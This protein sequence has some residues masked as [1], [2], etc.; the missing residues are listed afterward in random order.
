ME[1]SDIIKQKIKNQGPITF[2][3]FMEMALY[4]PGLGYYTSAKEKIGEKGDF[5]TSSSLSPAFGAMIAKQLE[6]MFALLGE[7][8]FTVVEYGAGTGRL[9][10]DI[11]D[12]LKQNKELYPKLNYC[13]VEKS[14]AMRAKEKNILNEKVTWCN[15]ISELPPLKGCVL[16]NELVDNFAV[17][18]VVMQDELMEVFVDFQNGFTEVLKPASKELVNY[19]NELKVELPKGFRTEINLDATLWMKDVSKVLKRGY[20]LT[21]DYG[22]PSAELYC[23]QRKNGTIACYNKH[24]VNYEPFADIGR[25]DITSHVNFSALCL[26]GHK[27]GLELCGYRDQGSFLI[28]LGFKDHIKTKVER[29]SDLAKL[30]QEVHL[31]NLL[32]EDMGRK[33]K[34]LI[35]QKETPRH[36][37]SGLRPLHV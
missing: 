1:L 3:D 29:K 10:K 23:E 13:I 15:S 17:H 19:L 6:E 24:K 9:C 25:Q 12:H 26:W 11:L 14:P 32:L 37:L 34:V 30:K 31:S 2:R 27:H 4:Y 35:Q 18:Q 33:F 8:K 28:A 7:E 36:P 22:Y 20:V 21:I 5:Y 16:S